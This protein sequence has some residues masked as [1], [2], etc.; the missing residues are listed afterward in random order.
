MKTVALLGGM[1]YEASAL[2]YKIINGYV[3]KQLGGRYSAPLILHSFNFH[4]LLAAMNQGHWDVVADRFVD[5]A[6]HMKAA[7]AE[8]LVICANYP[9]KI[10]DVVEQRSGMHVLHIADLTAEEIVRCGKRK[11]G[12]LGMKMVMEEDYIKGRMKER[13]GI[14]VLV[15]LEQDAR[16]SIH[17]ELMSNLPSGRVTPEL[18]RL[19]IQSS[20]AMIDDGAEGIILGSTDL[21]FALKPDD[22]EVPLFDTNLV[23][24]EG[25]ARWLL[26]DGADPFAWAR[27]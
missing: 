15:P 13:Y 18:R 3:R 23:H 4:P 27:R 2:Y 21:A 10:A 14:D 20:R 1:T 6:S 9:H 24:A 5:A 8:G 12:L 19:L 26:G 25:V 22:V 7:G 16:D 11:V 17:N